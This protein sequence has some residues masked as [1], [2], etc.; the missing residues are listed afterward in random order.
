MSMSRSGRA[1]GGEQRTH[2]QEN[3][4]SRVEENLS[5]L[6][7]IL[8][9]SRVFSRLNIYLRRGGIWFEIDN[10]RI[11]AKIRRV[12]LDAFCY[13]TATMTI[14]FV[15][16]RRWMREKDRRRTSSIFFI[17][18]Y[19][20]A[21]N[22]IGSFLLIKFR[23]RLSLVDDATPIFRKSTLVFPSVDSCVLAIVLWSKLDPRIRKYFF[24]RHSLTWS[25]SDG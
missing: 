22:E 13:R 3:G 4:V 19:T 24:C 5:R 21:R 11:R 10:I 9:L 14:F 6:G 8:S 16:M 18:V 15:A 17:C 7:R 1:E 12:P 23:K 25:F 20:R 2:A